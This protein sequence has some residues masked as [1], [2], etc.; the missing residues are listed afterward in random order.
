VK[1]EGVFELLKRPMVGL[2]SAYLD[3]LKL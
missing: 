2:F 1:S 3:G